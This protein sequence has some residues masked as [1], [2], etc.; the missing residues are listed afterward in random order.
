MPETA[1][2]VADMLNTK[3]RS[4]EQI[5]EFGIEKEYHV[6]DKPEVLFPRFDVKEILKKAEEIKAEQIKEFNRE[7]GAPEPEK[8]ESKPTIEFADFEKVELKVGTIVDSVKVEGSDKLLKNTVKL[9][10]ETRTIVSGIA[11][12]YKP[13]DIIGKQVVVVTNLAPRKLKGI[14]SEGM[15]LCAYDDETKD[16]ALV[17]PISNF[18]D[19]CEVS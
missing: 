13:E 7:N 17:S 6:T 12:T 1:Q 2:K 18:K 8:V 15:I 10:S 9:G 11:K 16:L 5:S 14:L 19:G 3:L 4:V